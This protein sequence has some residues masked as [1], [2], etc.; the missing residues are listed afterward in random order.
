MDESEEEE[1]EEEEDVVFLYPNDE[2]TIQDP[3]HPEDYYSFG[4]NSKSKIGENYTMK[5]ILKNGSIKDCVSAYAYCMFVKGG[6]LYY[7][8]RSSSGPAHV[9]TIK[10][11]KTTMEFPY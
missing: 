2:G 3:E 9:R 5:R 7:R 11:E 8:G 10:G 1:E 6:K 4:N